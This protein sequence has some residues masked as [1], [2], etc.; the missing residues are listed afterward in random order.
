MKKFNRKKQAI[1]SYGGGEAFHWYKVGKDTNYPSLMTNIL[2]TYVDWSD[3]DRVIVATGTHILSELSKEYKDSPFEFTN[4][5]SHEGFLKEM[6]QSEILLS[7]AG[8]VTTQEAFTSQTPLVYLPPSNN[9]HYILQDE[10]EER[11]PDLP[12]VHLSNYLEWIDLR[13]KPEEETIPAVME[14]LRKVEKSTEIQKSIGHDLNRLVKNRKEWSQKS[15]RHNAE[16]LDTLGENG[17]PAVV[18]KI[19]HLLKK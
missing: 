16:F 15:V 14:Q 19:E 3:F 12:S 8:L 10:L 7:T 11:I 1:I 6:A 9:S 5:G 17:A 4:C 2:N 18:D 13:D